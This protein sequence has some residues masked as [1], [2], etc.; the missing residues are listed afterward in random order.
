MDLGWVAGGAAAGWAAGAALRGVVFRG[1]VPFGAPARTLCPHCAAP[2]RSRAPVRCAGC[3]GRIGAPMALEAATATVLALL[4]ARF[5][6]QPEVLAFAFLGVLGVALAAI[7]VAVQRL[8]DRL[9]LPAYPVLIAL[10]GVAAL[11]Q[12]D[13][14]ALVRALLGGLA[15]G[16]AFLLLAL[17][18][19]GGLGGGDVKAA[20]L[21]GI[22]LGWLGWPA[23]LVGASLGFVLMALVSVVLLAAGRI[24]LRSSIAFGPFLLAGA[25]LGALGPA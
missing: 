21:T 15:M 14:G 22:A 20:G 23:L 13:G 5:A 19:A 24:T 25:L 11:V 6:G 9:V 12:R 4:A 18:R 7:D 17:L 1:S 16:G 3:G 8:P 2:V 10:F